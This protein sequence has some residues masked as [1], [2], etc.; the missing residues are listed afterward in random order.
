MSVHA[1][2]TIAAC[3]YCSYICDGHVTCHTCLLAR[4]HL[5]S[6]AVQLLLAMLCRDVNCIKFCTY[7][8][9]CLLMQTVQTVPSFVENC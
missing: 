8:I 4:S 1:H 7:A 9:T 5:Q 2:L 3:V 6:T